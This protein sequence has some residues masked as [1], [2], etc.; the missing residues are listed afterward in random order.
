VL[1]AAWITALIALGRRL[2]ERVMSR[3]E[4]QGG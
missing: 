3:L 2:T 1:M 4:V